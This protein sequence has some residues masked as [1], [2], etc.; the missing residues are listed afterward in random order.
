MKD[1][2]LTKAEKKNRNKPLEA[3]KAS[4]GPEYPYGL[5][6]ELDHESMGKLGMSKLPKIGS[7]IKFHAHAHV[8]SASQDDSTSGSR[9]RVGLQITHM[10]IEPQNAT[11]AVDRGL[12]EAED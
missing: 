2:K 1:M 7:K 6:V 9:K 12:A 8:K 10:A 5:S 3:A 11:D 4:D